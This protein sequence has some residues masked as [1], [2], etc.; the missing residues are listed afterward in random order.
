MIYKGA[1]IVDYS[2]QKITQLIF[3]HGFKGNFPG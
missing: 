3:I 2:A 1:G